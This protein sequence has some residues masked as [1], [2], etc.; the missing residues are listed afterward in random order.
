MEIEFVAYAGD[1]R[2]F[3]YLD[4]DGRRLTDLLNEAEEFTVRGVLLENLADG[5]LIE[6][7]QATIRRDELFAAEGAGPRGEVHRRVRTRAHSLELQLGPYAVV[8]QAH[9]FPGADPLTAILRRGPGPMVPLTE[10]TIAFTRADGTLQVREVATLIVN[11][12]HADWIRPARADHRT[13]P[14]VPILEPA[15]GPNL[16]KD[17]TGELAGPPL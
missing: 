17:L 13:V 14:S 9:A 15:P 10:A 16:A 7:P 8:G 2:I 12:E 11:R 5:R 1:C 4:L 6:V 3:T